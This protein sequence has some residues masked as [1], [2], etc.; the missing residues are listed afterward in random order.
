MSVPN[1]NR[2]KVLRSSDSVKKDFFKISNRN[3]RIAMY[4]L[5]PNTFK[6]YCYLADNADGY[7]FDLYPCEFER[8]ANVSYD[9]YKRSFQELKEKGFLIPHR[10]KSNVFLFIEESQNETLHDPNSKDI[11]E[12]IQEDEFDLEF[13]NNFAIKSKQNKK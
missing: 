11:I 5:K 4:N 3:L 7:I 13:A 8:F 6:L 9:T 2:I 12:S 1:Q 10:E